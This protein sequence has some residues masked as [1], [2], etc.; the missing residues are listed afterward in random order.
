MDL[1]QK[2][3]VITGAGRGLGQAMALKFAAQGAN[4]ALLDLKAEDIVSTQAA[5]AAL[6]VSAR[7][8]ACNVTSETEVSSVM[9]QIVSDFGRLDVLI[10]NAGIV[11]DALLVKVK[12]GAVVGTMS[13]EQ[14]NAVI[15]TNLTGVFLCGRE[16][17]AQMIRLQHG[18]VIINI[19]SVSRAGNNG[20]TNYAAAKAGVVAMTTT[21]AKELARY[22]IR[23]GAIAPGFCATEIL[24]AMAPE[25]LAKVTAPV[26]LKRLGR[27][28]E[29]AEA[30][31]FIAHNDFFSGRVLEVDGGLRF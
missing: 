7:S 2:T 5:C 11:R 30:A 6:N 1:T 29:I 25:I 18:G 9:Q 12:D 13:L 24:N 3:V 15:Q 26:P 19:S 21:W 22:Q 17:A 27:P 20:Q 16:A 31:L 10:N 14:W 8:Y 28:E 4:L 23:T